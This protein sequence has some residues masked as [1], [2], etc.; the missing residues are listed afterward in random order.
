MTYKS[1]TEFG[2]KV[3]NR[4]SATLQQGALIAQGDYCE[5]IGLDDFRSLP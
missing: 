1:A 2:T 3:V 5:N 4:H